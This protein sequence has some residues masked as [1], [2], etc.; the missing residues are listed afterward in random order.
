[1]IQSTARKVK[2]VVDPSVYATV[3]TNGDGEFRYRVG[4]KYDLQEDK[5]GWTPVFCTPIPAFVENG[6]SEWYAI[7]LVSRYQNDA[8]TET[9]RAKAALTEHQ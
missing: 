1:M 6:K 2:Q 7:G 4:A 5:P 9:D 3:Y 8:L